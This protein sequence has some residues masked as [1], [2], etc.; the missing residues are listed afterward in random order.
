M[1]KIPDNSQKFPI[2]HADKQ[3]LNKNYEVNGRLLADTNGIF[4][5]LAHE[6]GKIH[7]N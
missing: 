3:D 5:F 2:F 1:R 6:P 4:N 7:W